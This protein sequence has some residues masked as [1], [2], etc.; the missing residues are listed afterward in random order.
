MM[1]FFRTI[2]GQELILSVTGDT[3]KILG[4][5]LERLCTFTLRP[6][7]PR[8]K[9]ETRSF[10][11]RIQPYQ[12]DPFPLGRSYIRMSSK[13]VEPYNLINPGRAHN[14][15]RLHWKLSKH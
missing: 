12:L 13:Q 8:E 14:T 7:L 11:R 6:I 4:L 1:R 15:I 3:A 10:R 2:L 5:T 9:N